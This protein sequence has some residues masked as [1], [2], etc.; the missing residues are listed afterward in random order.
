MTVSC[1]YCIDCYG[2]TLHNTADDRHIKPV[3]RWTMSST[4]VLNVQRLRMLVFSTTSC[5]TLGNQHSSALYPRIC[6]E[7]CCLRQGRVCRSG[8]VYARDLGIYIDFDLLMR[9]HVQKTASR[10]FAVLRQLRQIRQSI[11]TDA[12][13]YAGTIQTRDRQCRDDRPSSLSAASGSVCAEC[14]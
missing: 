2:L 6:I 5:Y 9:T 4:V 14:G 13:S 12:A 10:C 3:E 11:S 8:M 1:D 7:R